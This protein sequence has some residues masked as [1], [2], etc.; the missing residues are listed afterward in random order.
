[1][2]ERI[3]RIVGVCIYYMDQVVLIFSVRNII[4]SQ[5]TFKLVIE[6]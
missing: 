5:K 3:E 6:R 1:M 2:T 4:L